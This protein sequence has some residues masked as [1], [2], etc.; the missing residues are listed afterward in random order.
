MS[1]QLRFNFT[2]PPAISSPDV[3]YPP[4]P[5][6]YEDKQSF[7]KLL[8][9]IRNFQSKVSEISSALATE[10]LERQM[11]MRKGGPF[12]D[13]EHFS[14]TKQEP[15][16]QLSSRITKVI[17]DIETALQSD[18]PPS[19]HRKTSVFLEG[20]DLLEELKSWAASE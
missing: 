15:V 2:Q 19:N 5:L 6:T 12:F 13:I 7:N 3:S 4:E 10:R 11:A 18:P 14:K 20:I 16:T 1:E 8:S 9:D 17:T